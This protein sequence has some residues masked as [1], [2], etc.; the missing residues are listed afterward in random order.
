[1]RF[2]GWLA[3]G[4]VLLGL[5]NL[6]GRCVAAQPESPTQLVQRLVHAIGS[7]KAVENGGVLSAAEAANNTAAARAANTILDIPG[8]CR[9]TLGR[10]WK[11]RSP[12]EQQAFIALIE[13]LFARVAYPR[14]AEFFS[15]LDVTIT[16]E[17]IRG[18]RAVVNTAVTH[19]KEGLITIDYRL[20]Q[21]DG[22]WRV[23]DILL[24]DVSLAA[25]LRSQFN[26]IIIRHSYAE[27]IRRMKEKIEEESS[28]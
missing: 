23:R 14:S 2:K 7:M 13:E 10:H 26:K 5:S 1:M 25:N 18:T 20:R 15:D 3:T 24:D 12:E 19:T 4:L 27:L 16:G 8:V 28:G 17:R 6:A 21:N 22:N 11:A 9:W